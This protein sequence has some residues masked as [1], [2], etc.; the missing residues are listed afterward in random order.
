MTAPAIGAGD[1][2]FASGPT[3]ARV[4][5]LDEA[6]AALDGQLAVVGETDAAMLIEIWRR[7]ASQARLGKHVRVGLGAR[8]VNAAGPGDLAIGDHA[9]VRGCL[10]VEAGGGMSVGAFVYVG[11][12]AIISAQQ[13]IEIGDATLIAHGVMVFD[14]NSHPINPHAREIHFRRM[15]GVL[16]R[17]APIVIEASPVRIGRRCWI[18]MNSLV[19]RGVSIGDDTIVAGGSVVTADLPAGVVAGGNPARVIRPL[20]PE[21]LAPPPAA[22]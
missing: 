14:N 10:R 20:T 17:D 22:G 8:V 13:S 21:E 3:F 15:L 12:G 9:V 16:D 1:H 7:L 11:D 4:E 2:A 19:M 18:G 5:T 6:R